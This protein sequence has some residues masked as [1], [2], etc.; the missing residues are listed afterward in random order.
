MR[1]LRKRAILRCLRHHNRPFVFS[2]SLFFEVPLQT[3]KLQ[4]FKGRLR[5][6][7]RTKAYHVCDHP[8]SFQQSVQGGRHIALERREVRR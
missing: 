1:E 5:P 3:E 6:Y 8:I 7:V 4:R 2:S